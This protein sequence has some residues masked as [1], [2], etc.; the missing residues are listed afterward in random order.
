MTDKTVGLYRYWELFRRWD[1]AHELNQKV[2]SL[3]EFCSTHTLK[4]DFVCSFLLMV[5]VGDPGRRLVSYVHSLMSIYN[6]TITDRPV[7]LTNHSI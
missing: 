7:G 5:V 4:R 3:H 6:H 1:K 2:R